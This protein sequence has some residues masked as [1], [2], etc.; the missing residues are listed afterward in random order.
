MIVSNLALAFSELGVS[1]GT[2]RVIFSIATL[3]VIAI[4]LFL[5]TRSAG[6]EKDSLAKY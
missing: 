2:I 3:I 5:V 6:E 1:T 4:P